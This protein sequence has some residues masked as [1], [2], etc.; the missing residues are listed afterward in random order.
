MKLI[1]KI[2]TNEI[3][4]INPSIFRYDLIFLLNKDAIKPKKLTKNN[5]YKRD[6]TTLTTICAP[7]MSKKAE[8]ESMYVC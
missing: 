5:I 1:M 4:I 3:P 2:I 6:S 7:G 8:N